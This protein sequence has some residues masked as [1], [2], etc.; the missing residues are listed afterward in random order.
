MDPDKWRRIKEVFDSAVVL[1]T[2]AQSEYVAKACQDDSEVL[3]EVQTLLR[4]HQEAASRFLNQTPLGA[5]ETASTTN[6][7]RSSRAIGSR[8][9][10]Y[11][12]VKE[13]G[14]GGMGEVY[15]AARVDG[16][17]EK[18]VAIKFVR[19]GFDT[20][21]VVERFRNE[22]QILASLDHPNI[23]RLL[24]G[25]TTDDGVP[26]L[27]MELIEGTPIDEYCDQRALEI[28]PR[29][30]LFRQVC[31]AVQ[32]A[33]QHLVIHRDIKPGNILVGDDGTPKLLDFGIA[34]ILDPA[35]GS[36]PTQFRPM[37]PEYASPEQVRGAPITTATDIYSLGVV[38]YQLLTGRSPYVLKTRDSHELAQAICERDPQ[39]PSSRIIGRRPVSKSV[40]DSPKSEPRDNTAA[41]L[42]RR[43][44]G[45]LDNILLMALRK[46]P[47]KR[48]AFV[49]QFSDDIRRNIEGLPVL[50]T[51]GS[52]SYRT[53]KFVLRNKGAVAAVAVVL[54]SLALG[55]ILTLREKRIAERRFNDVRALANSLIFEIDDSIRDLP[56]ATSARKLLVSRALQYLDRLSGEASGDPSLQRE[57]ATAYERVGD[58]LGHPY[59]A[60]LGDTPGALA[61]YRKALAIRESLA[62]ASMR[63]DAKLQNEIVGNYFRIA[64]VL[65]VT[66]DRT[67]ALDAFQRA[68]PI[69]QQLKQNSPNPAFAD[70]L[71]G[72][73]YF[74]AQLLARGGD[75]DHALANYEQARNIRSEALDKDPQ[76]I[77]LRSHLAADYIGIAKSIE[78]NRRHDDAIA[79]EAKAVEILQQ[80]SRDNPNSASLREYYAESLSQIA[81]LYEAKGDHE[82]AVTSARQS[83]EM[84]GNLLKA[85]P[86]DHL[87]R[88]NFAF[89]DLNMG[90]PLLHLKKN[91]AALEDF[92]EAV[93]T[94]EEMSPEKSGDRYLRSGLAQA[95]LDVGNA[96]LA[97]AQT[98]ANSW[99]TRRVTEARTWYE[100]SAQVWEQKQKLSEVDNDESGE[101]NLVLAAQS[102]CDEILTGKSAPRH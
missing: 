18:E 29:L 13:I 27:V 57:L 30:E 26:Y 89:T 60:N 76:N 48:Y 96:L 64:N 75:H 23:A 38:L 59:A 54:V 86:K 20:A 32:Y 25:G 53:R 4:H 10:V 66:S 17:Y 1:E 93:K 91:E 49:A 8:I 55:L 16:T 51:R 92:R 70:Q 12:I 15:R 24:D 95:Y 31:G 41:K 37:T 3:S 14:H 7:P 61:S 88:T 97:M 56:G 11:Q 19:G 87:A 81:G 80:L 68:L 102:H 34:K 72:V 77:S 36:E 85:D 71:A 2:G 63:D 67:G 50:A 83:H 40:I 78:L 22:R 73:H 43:L 74:I 6:A 21:S 98:G 44:S 79:M 46:E 9:G 65:E 62:A 82:Q 5:D 101:L 47:E 39:K 42:K 69:A 84:F 33:H 28:T 90:V 99:D 35:A 52:W 45:D 58:V 100:K 94:F